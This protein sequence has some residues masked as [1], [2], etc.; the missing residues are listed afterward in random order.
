MI[1]GP[2]GVS[3]GIMHIYKHEI[4]REKGEIYPWKLPGD[5]YIPLGSGILSS[6]NVGRTTNE[7]KLES[8]VKNTS[9]TLGIHVL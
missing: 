3:G 2:D 4:I 8:T 7:R 1:F 6:L 5:I 9:Y